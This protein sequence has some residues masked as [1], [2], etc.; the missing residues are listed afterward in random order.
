MRCSMRSSWLSTR[1]C[2]FSDNAMA[3]PLS[4]SSRRS[5]PCSLIRS[6]SQ[7]RSSLPVM[8]SL[9]S[10]GSCRPRAAAPARRR[11]ARVEAP[12][13]LLGGCGRAELAFGEDAE[14][15]AV[16]R[17]QPVLRLADAG[18]ALDHHELGAPPAV[19]EALLQVRDA[20]AD[21]EAV[22]C[23]AAVLLLR[24]GAA[25]RGGFVLDV[26]GSGTDPRQKKL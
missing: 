12:A 13:R 22:A 5:M 9:P 19:R 2:D 8:R 15:D 6:W 24:R 4:A 20:L 14:G 17:A 21:L 3:L 10:A 26:S 7:T 25:C 1:P 11:K 16:R 18:E 23:H